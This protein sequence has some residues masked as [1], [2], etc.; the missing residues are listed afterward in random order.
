MAAEIRFELGD[1][2]EVSLADLDGPVTSRAD[3]PLA[4][5]IRLHRRDDLY[6]EDAAH[7]NNTT[8]TRSVPITSAMSVVV[9][10]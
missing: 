8:A 5:C 2:H 4:S 6:P 7:T 9:F 10:W 3:I 1:D